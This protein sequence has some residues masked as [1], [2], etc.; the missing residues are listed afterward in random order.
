MVALDDLVPEVEHYCLGNGRPNIGS[1][2][3][4]KIALILLLHRKALPEIVSEVLL[5]RSEKHPFSGCFY[6]L[7][8]NIV[9]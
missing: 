3:L 7:S 4:I 1:V 8:M 2:V 9:Q 6:Y 5:F